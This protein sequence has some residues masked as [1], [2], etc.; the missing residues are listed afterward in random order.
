[1]LIE[2]HSVFLHMMEAALS[3]GEGRG[4]GDGSE[5]HCRPHADKK[6]T[7]RIREVAA[8]IEKRNGCKGFLRA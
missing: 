6:P 7:D 8:Y 5:R 1:V 3:L 4:L 2:R